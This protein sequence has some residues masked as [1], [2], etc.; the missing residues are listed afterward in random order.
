MTDHASSV[1]HGPMSGPLQ[2]EMSRAREV[3]LMGLEPTTPCLQSRCSSR[4]S[5]SPEVEL[6]RRE[7]S[8]EACVQPREEAGEV[9]HLGPAVV[10][11]QWS[12]H[13]GDIRAEYEPAAHLASIGSES[14]G[15]HEA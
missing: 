12:D 14:D 13:V 3:Q 1:R 2:P 5:Q 8:L 10:E 9:G 6:R 11:H 15:M 7:S 4:L